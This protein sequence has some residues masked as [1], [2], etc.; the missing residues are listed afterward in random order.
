MPH[1]IHM[2]CPL[3]KRSQYGAMLSLCALDRIWHKWPLFF[4]SSCPCRR[5]LTL[6]TQWTSSRQPDPVSSKKRSSD[7]RWLRRSS[8]DRG[9]RNSNGEKRWGTDIIT[10]KEI[11]FNKMGTSHSCFLISFLLL[12]KFLTSTPGP[13]TI[14]NPKPKHQSKCLVNLLTS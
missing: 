12:T 13:N 2:F 1:F 6:A 11:R 10:L 5:K 4:F 3:H 8:W 9:R 14:L 7:D